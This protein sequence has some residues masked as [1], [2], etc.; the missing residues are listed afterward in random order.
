VTGTVS[1]AGVRIARLPASHAAGVSQTVCP[2]PEEATHPRCDGEGYPDRP[3]RASN[4]EGE[5]WTMIAGLSSASIRQ[6]CAMPLRLRRRGVMGM[7]AISARSTP[8]KQRRASSSPSLQ[9]NIVN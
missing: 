1:N 2:S 9:P 7:F 4:K 8:R 6:S 3:G 5:S